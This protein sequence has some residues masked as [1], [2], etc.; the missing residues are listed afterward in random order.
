MVQLPYLISLY[1]AENPTQVKP[2][3]GFLY[4]A[5]LCSGGSSGITVWVRPFLSFYSPYVS[6]RVVGDNKM[7]KPIFERIIKS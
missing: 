1:M 5:A 2:W 4:L 6:D 3:A 7:Q